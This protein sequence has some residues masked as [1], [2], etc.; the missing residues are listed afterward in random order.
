MTKQ[1]RLIFFFFGGESSMSEIIF[2]CE[3]GKVYKFNRRF[4]G[5]SSRCIICKR[6]YVVPLVSEQIQQTVPAGNVSDDTELPFH[7]PAF[8]VLLSGSS[9]ENN[10]NHTFSSDHHTFNP[11][12][13]PPAL[14]DFNNVQSRVNA[15]QSGVNDVQD[16]VSGI[17]SGVNSVVNYHLGCYEIREKIGSGG[18]G[19]V[20][21]A[22]DTQLQRNVTIKTLNKKRQQNKS[23]KERF[24]NEARI[25]GKLVHSGVIPIYS[26]DYDTQGEP[27]YVMRLL[28]GQTFEQLIAQYH[29]LKGT[30][31][32][33]EELR[34]LIRHFINVCQT[35]AYAHDQHVVHRDI[36]PSNI[37]LSGYGE[38]IML[39]WGL[40][41]ILA[42]E[43]QNHS[44]PNL[45]DESDSNFDNNIEEN[46]E[47]DEQTFD[48]TLAGG[49]VG[50]LGFQSP[51]YLRDGNSRCSDDIYALG[52]TLYF[53]LGNKLPYK[54]SRD[55]RGIFDLLMTPPKPPHLENNHVS[56]S[57]S[58][59]CLCALAADR[60]KRYPSA[61][62]LATD[63]QHW[64]DGNTISVYRMSRQEK[65]ELLIQKNAI[66]F[67]AVA[68]AFALGIVLTRL[69]TG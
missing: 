48:L 20:F 16:G 12:I 47:T 51:E 30:H 28:E 52:V 6:E 46:L 54:V 59:V 13:I 50:T 69:L 27:Y 60:T 7:S 41:K 34:R 64:L 14:P 1:N 58:A 8:S 38:T 24:I 57:L 15:V 5:R 3:C 19:T 31:H 35:I 22:W 18:M 44:N 9:D 45:F 56:R 26:L 67:G 42:P 17:Q 36:K 68:I 43:Q 49:R 25:T 10:F 33:P 63:L 23:Y 29:N 65:L 40:A 55:H 39:D 61:A 2:T 66:L 53:L 32:T 21:Y 37:M 4:S 62:H 11:A